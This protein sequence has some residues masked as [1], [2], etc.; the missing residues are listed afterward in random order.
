MVKIKTKLSTDDINSVIKKLNR[1]KKELSNIDDTISKTLAEE[2]KNQ[3]IKNYALKGFS[4]SDKPT[5]GIAKY[6]KGYKAFIRGSSVIYDEFGTGDT[7]ARNGHPWK[8]DYS[9]NPYNSGETIRQ[10][11][12]KSQAR[13]GIGSGLYWTY[14]DDIKD[15]IVA[16]Q[17]VPSGKFMYKSAMWL[18][19]NYKSI[20]K[21][22]VDDVLSKL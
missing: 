16:T 14:Y 7:G 11:N 17:G 1:L 8:G 2:T 20:V 22:K 5:I 4:S 19:D 6:S 12:E 13:Y 3:I 15:M 18:K 21:E 9:L 10:A